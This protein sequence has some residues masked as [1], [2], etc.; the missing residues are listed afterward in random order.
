MAKQTKKQLKR[1]L[2]QTKKCVKRILKLIIIITLS[3]MLSADTPTSNKALENPSK[4]VDTDTQESG[5]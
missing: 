1:Q 5:C 3:L 4:I 2:R